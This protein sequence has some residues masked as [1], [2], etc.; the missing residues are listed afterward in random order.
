MDKLKQ[1]VVYKYLKVLLCL[2]LMCVYP[3]AYMYLS[4]IG[5][6]KIKVVIVPLFM[7]YMIAFF[8]FHIV[9][10]F[11]KNIYKSGTIACVFMLIFLNFNIVYKFIVSKIKINDIFLLV[12]FMFFWFVMSIYIVRSKIDYDLVVCCI[13]F[14]FGGLILFNLIMAVPKFTKM[15]PK[16]NVIK[17]EQYAK[18]KN[19]RPNI[20]YVLL[21]EYA[22]K[23][24]LQYYYDFDNSKFL[25]DIEKMGFNISNT[26]YNYEGILTSEIV[27]NILNLNYVTEI[28]GLQINNL[29]LL[30]NPVMYRFFKDLGYDINIINHLGLF[31]SKDVNVLYE[32][33]NADR[34]KG[35]GAHD[36]DYYLIF[37]S[38]IEQ[39]YQIV[40]KTQKRS[41]YDNYRNDCKNAI[42]MLKNSCDYVGDKP[43]FTLCYLMLP[44][45]PFVFDEKGQPI[46]DEKKVYNWEIPELYINQLKYLN[47]H[48]EEF[49]HNVKEKDPNAVIVIQ[50]DHGIRYAYFC[51]SDYA[52]DEYNAALETEKMQ[53][54]LNCVYFGGKKF[55]IEGMS[56]INTWRKI[57]NELYGTNYEMINPEKKFVY[58]WKYYIGANR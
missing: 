35:V 25:N 19:N 16:K 3:C 29:N 5:E 23:E 13:I 53:N 58:K 21:D 44:H 54:A 11:A 31:D 48:L 15:N 8:V 24:N 10:I 1:S 7:F 45:Q 32:T 27:P 14:A 42:N 28:D 33:E 50:G 47:G 36:V 39:I 57:L 9:I 2:L 55:D 22:G 17:V 26:T 4:N 38:A 43:T 41:S 20:Y 6:T 30:D 40:K 34:E 49:I 12:L 46:D 52:K 56:A 51:M 18:N 37:N